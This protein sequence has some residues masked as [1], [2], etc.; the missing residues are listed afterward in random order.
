MSNID[1]RIPSIW[2]ISMQ[3]NNHDV[4]ATAKS[5]K[6]E[7]EHAKI[8][9]YITAVWS[10]A[11]MEFFCEFV[12]IPGYSKAL[13]SSFPTCQQQSMQKVKLHYKRL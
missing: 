9:I 4:H 7:T 5:T 6:M 13:S 8:K 11:T 12:L 10:I 2:S 1:H 3:T